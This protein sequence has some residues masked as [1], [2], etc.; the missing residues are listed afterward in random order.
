MGSRKERK[1]RAIRVHRRG[2][3]RVANVTAGGRKRRVE[4]SL[5]AL[6][7]RR[8]SATWLRTVSVAGWAH[9]ADCS[10]LESSWEVLKWRWPVEMNFSRS[11]AVKRREGQ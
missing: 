2:L 8:S 9:E 5:L 10:G 1:E 3:L 6:T 7:T 4:E 11:L